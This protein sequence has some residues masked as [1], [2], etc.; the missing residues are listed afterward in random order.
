MYYD[1]LL[2]SIAGDVRHF[3]GVCLWLLFRVLP[4]LV[5]AGLSV[6][7]LFNTA[8]AG[9]GEDEPPGGIQGGQLFFRDQAGQ[10]VPAVTQGSEVDIEINGMVARVVLTQR[11]RNV[12]QHFVE[13]VYAFPL[14]ENAAVRRMEMLVGER[15]IVGK[16]REREE[17]RKIYQQA[18]TSGKRAALVEQQRP[19]LFTNRVANIGPGEDIAVE[20][21]YS[22]E[23]EYRA[24]QFSLRF[25]STI[26]PR[27]MPGQPAVVQEGDA[28]PSGYRVDPTHGWAVPTDQVPD[29]DA[30]SPFLH[31]A[32]GG[33]DSPLN[34]I[35][36]SARLDMGMP[37]ASV[38]APYHQIALARRAGVYE[39]TLAAGRAEMNRDFLLQWRPVSGSAPTAA[40]FTESVAGEHYGLLMVV[41][42]SG[43]R[44]VEVVPR[45]IVFVI[46]TSGSMGGEP[47][48]QARQSLGMA[49][50]QLREEDYFNIIAFN[51]SHRVL[52]RESMPATFHHVQVATEFVRHLNASGGTEMMP[53]L[54]AA[55]N[56]GGEADALRDRPALRQIVFITDGAVG[57]ET[58]LFEAIDRDLGDNRLFTVGIG[59]APNSWFMREAARLGR[60]TFSYVGDVSEVSASMTTLFEQLAHPVAVGLR[61]DWPAGAEVWPR[62]T[63][64]LYRGQPLLLAVKFGP[65][66]PSDELI[67]SGRLAGKTWRSQ[68]NYPTAPPTGEA[69]GHAG[70]A[71][72]WARRKIAGLLEGKLR[73]QSEEQVRA[74]VLPLALRHQL[75]SPYTSFVA[76]EEKIHRPRD[77]D[78]QSQPVPNTPP[79]GQSPQTFAYPRTATTA[80]ANLWLGA[81]LVLGLIVIR[82]VRHEA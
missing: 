56:A 21:E 79:R 76:V 67:V 24:G 18:K 75:L 42:P 15:R 60:G 38:D 62:R 28:E 33:D 71:S 65:N 31:T 52:F 16:V 19:N 64:D 57:N 48:R 50:N 20:L 55:L 8:P 72:I 59:S 6:A 77:E 49:L 39:I 63:P 23:V 17:A 25:P 1:R 32:A 40:L 10:F 13:G 5:L 36:I 46:D 45:E 2:P 34:S 53:A 35:E 44:A 54:L 58:A 11:F 37:L 82:L 41:P 43:E 74:G 73:G 7:F 68:L 29:A 69:G 9:A 3:G 30:I 51:A 80:R 47:I 78:L 12:S 27:Y 66:W 70:V 61:L 22:Q 4:A 26:T 14:P 81:F